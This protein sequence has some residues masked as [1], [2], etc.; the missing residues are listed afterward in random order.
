[1]HGKI[2][3]YCP[4]KLDPWVIWPDDFKFCI[5]NHVRPLVDQNLL[6]T[7]HEYPSE[8]YKGSNKSSWKG[9]HVSGTK[10]LFWPS[11]PNIASEGWTMVKIRPKE[12]LHV[13]CDCWHDYFYA[14]LAA[15]WPADLVTTKKFYRNFLGKIS[16][17]LGWPTKRVAIRTASL[18]TRYRPRN[19]WYLK[20][21][22]KKS[23]FHRKMCSWSTCCLPWHGGPKMGP[24]G[25][26]RRFK[27]QSCTKAHMKALF[28]AIKL[29]ER[30]F[31]IFI[32]CD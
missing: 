5:L 14:Y 21:K 3:N 16:V 29:R 12:G 11:G 4:F 23:I 22:P 10:F 2:T 9:K 1:M 17:V 26:F 6:W 24:G 31:E 7:D 8:I 18:N 15:I 13:P 30:N 28:E 27:L 25:T 20:K 19:G 32:L